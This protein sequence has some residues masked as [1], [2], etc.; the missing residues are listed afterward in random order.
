MEEKKVE[1]DEHLIAAGECFMFLC[2]V[3]SYMRDFLVLEEGGE[4]MCRSYNKT[5]GCG[6]HPSDFAKKRLELGKHSFNKI[7]DKF[8]CKWPQWK[9]ESNVHESIERAVILR[10]GFGHANVQPFRRFLLYTPNITSWK[11]INKYMICHKCLQYYQSCQCQQ[12][13]LAEPPT[14]V[15][16]CLEERFLKMFKDVIK[17]INLDCFVPTARLLDVC[18]KGVAWPTENGYVIGENRSSEPK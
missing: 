2:L 17:T 11:S 12:E 7:K 18:Y 3:E 9:E 4:D 15:F 8:L 16:K 1:Y 10:N 13:N 5:F 6:N 14:L